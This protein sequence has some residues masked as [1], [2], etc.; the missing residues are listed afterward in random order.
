MT[1]GGLPHLFACKVRRPRRDDSQSRAQVAVAL[2]N[3]RG[4]EAIP[5]PPAISFLCGRRILVNHSIVRKQ[6]QIVLR[7]GHSDVEPCRYL[8]ACS[9]P[10]CRQKTNDRNLR[11]VAKSVNGPLQQGRSDGADIPGHIGNL[12]VSVRGNSYVA[13]IADSYIVR[14]GRVNAT[15][16]LGDKTL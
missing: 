6:H 13:K 11:L 1:T 4:I 15:I 5:H 16:D 8:A 12:A 2:S 10:V 3:L 14:Y 7:G 9:R